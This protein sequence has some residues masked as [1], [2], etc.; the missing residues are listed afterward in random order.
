MITYFCPT[1]VRYTA[2]LSRYYL[3]N[4]PFDPS[5]LTSETEMYMSLNISYQFWK[6]FCSNFGCFESFRRTRNCQLPWWVRWKVRGHG[7]AV[8]SLEDS[9]EG[10]S[11]YGKLQKI[12]LNNNRNILVIK[13]EKHNSK[14]R[15]RVG[16]PWKAN[17]SSRKTSAYT[18]G[19]TTTV[20][21]IGDYK[22]TYIYKKHLIFTH[23][24]SRYWLR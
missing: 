19:L 14:N 8:H 21:A 11:L 10:L 23:T 9:R 18:I 17:I 12:F 7:V 5:V 1:L 24:Y 20:T 3:S 22:D 13:F 6:A 16:C 4:K 2:F 15:W